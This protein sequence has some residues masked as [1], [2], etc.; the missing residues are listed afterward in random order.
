MGRSVCVYV[1]RIVC[2]F[3]CVCLYMCVLPVHQ[4]ETALPDHTHIK[5]YAQCV[6]TLSIGQMSRVSSK[7]SKVR[8]EGLQK[9]GKFTQHWG[10]L[11]QRRRTFGHWA[12]FVNRYFR[13]NLISDLLLFCFSPSLLVFFLVFFM[14]FIS[15]HHLFAQEVRCVSISV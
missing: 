12:G 10:H 8:Y 9:R 1:C 11:D 15:F 6:R 2:V 13:P 7:R 14:L 3:V 5:Q 4:S